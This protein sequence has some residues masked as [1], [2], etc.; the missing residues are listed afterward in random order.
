M[1]PTCCMSYLSQLNSQP[2]VASAG[3]ER[4]LALG[5]QNLKLDMTTC[6][7]YTPDSVFLSQGKGLLT[8]KLHTDGKQRA[9][10]SQFIQKALE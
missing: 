2:T 1:C 8:I 10:Y 9:S 7:M 6:D 4:F 3:R 5:V